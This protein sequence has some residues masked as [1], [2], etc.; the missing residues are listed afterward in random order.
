MSDGGNFCEIVEKLAA[1]RAVSDDGTI[2]SRAQG[3]NSRGRAD[4]LAQ[5]FAKHLMST[6]AYSAVKVLQQGSCRRVSHDIINL[7][8]SLQDR[9]PGTNMRLERI[10]P[11]LGSGIRE[12]WIRAEPYSCES[13]RAIGENR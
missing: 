10:D 2:P 1:K 11:S 4:I 12:E 13:K 9:A 8:S 6:A 3:R 7:P 5:R